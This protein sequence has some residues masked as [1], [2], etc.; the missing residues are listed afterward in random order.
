[1]QSGHPLKQRTLIVLLLAPIVLM[2]AIWGKEIYVLSAKRAELK[3]DFFEL[4]NIQYGLL[5]VDKWRENITDIVTMQIDQFR[6][7]GKQEKL[8]REALD[9]ILNSLIT[10]AEEMID[11]PQKGLGN[12]IKKFAFKTFVDTDKI[13]EKVPE[14]SKTIVD[15][16]KEPENKEKLKEL[17]TDKLE[18]YADQ[19]M[20]TLEEQSSYDK[21]LKKYSYV[22]PEF[23]SERIIELSDLYQA[24]IYLRSFNILGCMIMFL[25][26]WWLIRRQKFMYTPMFIMSVALALVVLLIGVLTPMIEIDARIKEINFLL[27]NKTIQFKDQVIFFQSKSIIDVVHILIKTKKADSIFVGVL[28]FTFSVLFPITKLICTEFYLLGT[29]KW[30]KSKVIK[31]FAFESSKWSMADVM[32]V[33]IFMAYIGFKGILDTQLTGLNLMTPS[34]ASITTN[35][36][37]LQ[38]GFILFIGFVLFSL[39]L[40]VI[41]KRI[42]KDPHFM[43][44]QSIP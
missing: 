9:D 6:L 5:S 33:A 29:R 21:I 30:K 19:T 25:L 14:F 20:A 44:E 16:I 31:F 27:M 7:K 34:I 3:K 17:A 10:Q 1:M 32:V 41:L 22:K 18:E 15:E 24:R 11:Q 26:I 8:L 23:I 12:K 4:N 37:S 38:P 35:Q 36:T 42:S 43:K 13:R 39:I 40:S 2:C 28:I